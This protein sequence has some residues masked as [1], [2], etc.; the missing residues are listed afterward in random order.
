MTTVVII[1]VLLALAGAFALAWWK[2]SKKADAIP[3]AQRSPV[4]VNGAPGD[5]QPKP[6]FSPAITSLASGLAASA[7]TSRASTPSAPSYP[8]PTSPR[9]PVDVDEMT[10]GIAAGLGVS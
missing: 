2:H 6:T 5:A 1:A 3:M 9:T 10:D 7:L 4:A 8:D